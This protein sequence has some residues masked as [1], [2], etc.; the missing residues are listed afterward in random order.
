MAAVPTFEWANPHTLA[1]ARRRL[2]LSPDDV[3]NQSKKRGFGYEPITKPELAQWEDGKAEPSL[4]NLEALA[5]LYVCPVGWFFLDQ[6]PN[7]L[8]KLDFRGVIQEDAIE[9]PGRQT[10]ARFLE[11]VEWTDA[12]ARGLGERITTNIG[13][14]QISDDIDELV[15]V[16]RSRIGFDP[17]IRKSWAHRDEAFDWWRTA[18]EGLGVFCFMMRL[19]TRHVRGASTWSE[20]G[21]AFILV[22]SEDAETAAGRTFTLLHE[23]GHLLLRESFVCDF[24]G[25]NQGSKVEQFANQFAA[26]MLIDKDELRKELQKLGYDHLRELWGDSTLDKIREPFFVSRDVVAILIEE[27]GFAPQGFYR[28]KRAQWAKYKG[29]GRASGPPV[30]RPL[31]QRKHRQV[32]FSLARLLSKSDHS[33]AVPLLDIADMLGVKVE[34]LPELFSTFQNVG[35]AR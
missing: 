19:P 30:K 21:G 17:A 14:A 29:F 6:V 11:F 1:Q 16:E 4:E 28:Q 9:G 2:G 8:Q 13:S 20:G 7:D 15:R 5:R 12:V 34:R 32:G 18:I 3:E 22:N 27:L 25:S 31:A 10:L 24:R 35:G 33:D 23:F 26:R